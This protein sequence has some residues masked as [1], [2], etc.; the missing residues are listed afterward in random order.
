MVAA[1]RE[2]EGVGR[3]KSQSTH[4]RVNL[5]G[6]SGLSGTF[7][8]TQL[9]GPG[10]TPAEVRLDDGR[11][12]RVPV[13]A[14]TRRDDGT[15]TLQIDADA[16]AAAAGDREV[17]AGGQVVIPVVAETLHVGKREVEAGRVR[18]TKVVSEREELV[19]QLLRKEEFEI[20]RVAVGREV[21]GPVEVRHEG[22]TLIIPLVEEVLVVEK[23]LVLREELRV[24]R[25]ST[26]VRDA[27]RVTLRSE[28]VRVERSA[29]KPEAAHGTGVA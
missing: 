11:I 28:D 3:L 13:D 24:T 18:V 29:G 6:V 14:L 10:H 17:S 25:R 7:D 22:E 26:E 23:R 19:E 12:L 21:S 9:E 15:F 8:A 20:E 1:A 2:R 4:A 5:A 27:Q 16:L